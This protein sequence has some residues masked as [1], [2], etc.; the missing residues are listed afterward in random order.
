MRLLLIFICIGLLVKVNA[1]RSITG[2]VFID[3]N[4][5]GIYNKGEQTISDVAI[6]NQRDVVLSDNKGRYKLPYT[7]NEFVFVTKPAGYKLKNDS[8]GYGLFYQPVDKRK[9]RKM[10]FPLYKKEENKTIH[11]ILV[12]DPQMADKVRLDY[13]R[14]GS[15]SHMM[16][17]EADFFMV[18]GDIAD[19][20]PS[21]FQQEKELMAKLGMDGYHVAGNHDANYE[22]SEARTHFKTFKKIY[23]PDYYSF[24][25]GWA[26]FVVLNNVNYFGWNSKDNKR[27]SYFG[28]VDKQQLTWLKN[29]LSTVSSDK[30]I[31]INTHIPL[32]EEYMDTASIAA[33]HKLL[34]PFD[35]IL[36]LSGHLHGVKAYDDDSSTLWNGQGKYESLV[37][38]ATCG[39]WWTGPYTETELP[40]ATCTDGTPKGYFILEL[41]ANDYNYRFVPE[42][43]PEDYQMRISSPKGNVELQDVEETEVIV[44]WFV[45]KEVDKVY[46][47][48][49]N[50][51]PIL[52]QRFTGV[53]PFIVAS[54]SKR[55]NN[56]HWTPGIVETDHLWKAKL[57]ADLEKGYHSIFVKAHKKN[58]HIYKTQKVLEVE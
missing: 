30:L 23:G 43:Y 10:N 7:G 42:L 26:H 17:Q 49:D 13:Y 19:D 34:E 55:I 11:T 37:V 46:M 3:E 27:G 1:Q 51:T 32:L 6:S 18:L 14:D 9:I 20:D 21:I 35:N 28:G 2:I 40:Y 25:Y 5:D 31:I 57:P 29:D 24:E 48:I 33:I 4:A 22:S 52:M 56:D 38:G 45:G 50:Q 44:N 54:L 58:G 47:Q 12:G 36:G 8:L 53:D 39:S 16:K 15:V 41:K